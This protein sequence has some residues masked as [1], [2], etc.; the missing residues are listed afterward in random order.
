MWHKNAGV[1]ARSVFRNGDAADKFYILSSGKLRVTAEPASPASHAE[2]GAIALGTI[3]GGE[4]FGES[5]LLNGKSRRTK[6]V[7]CAAG[8][9][10]KDVSERPET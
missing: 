10:L 5:S 2:S 6:T 9:V 7:T 4:G 3:H 8:R 1:A